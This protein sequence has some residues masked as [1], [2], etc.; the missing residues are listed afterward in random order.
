MLAALK[1]Y[2]TSGE[3]CAGSED[4]YTAGNGSLMRLAPAYA[5]VAGLWEREPL[6]AQ[7]AAVAAGSWREKEPPEIRGTG[8]VVEC[9]ALRER[10]EELAEALCGFPGPP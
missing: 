1:R 2:R 10:I 7:V 5:P 9:L 3:P 4:P 8:Y 6:C